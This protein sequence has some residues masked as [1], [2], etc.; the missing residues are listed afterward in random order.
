[1]LDEDIFQ[2]PHTFN[3]GAVEDDPLEAPLTLVKPYQI[4]R[5]FPPSPPTIPVSRPG[6]PPYPK[7]AEIEEAKKTIMQSMPE[8]ATLVE[9]ARKKVD[10]ADVDMSGDD[11]GIV[12]TPLGTGSAIPSKYR[13]GEIL[14]N[15]HDDISLC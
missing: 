13:N 9:E 5:I 10:Q 11:Y 3:K 8:Y 6:D 15:D 7:E 14:R 4:T 1:M 12:V 2:L